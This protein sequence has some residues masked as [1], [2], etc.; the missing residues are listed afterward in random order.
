M[1]ICILRKKRKIK[2]HTLKTL[3][4]LMLCLCLPSIALAQDEAEEAA[5]E[6]IADGIREAVDTIDTRDKFTKIV[7]YNDFSWEYYSLGRPVLDSVDFDDHWNTEKIHAYKELLLSEIPNEVDILLVDSLH[8]FVPPIVGKVRSRYSFRRTRP[9]RGTDIPLAVGTPVRAAFD[10]KVRIAEFSRRTG[11]YGNLIVLRHAN[12][13][14]TYYGHLSKHNVHPDEVVKAGEII[15]YGGNTGRSTGPHLHFEARYMGQAFDPERI[16]DFE[17]GTLRDTVFT[18]KKHYFSIYSHYGQTEEESIAASQRMT[19]TIRSGDTLGG[20]AAKY[21]T[22]V[23]NICK[24]NNIS[25]STTLRIGRR[26]IV[27]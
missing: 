4:T 24:L 20:L 11:G 5:E 19:H 2:R 8:A 12:G 17:N 6:E 25:R 18:V 22:T 10:G 15:G 14:E 7:L 23:S 13:L 26:L 21:G 9:H 27:R 3:A 1:Y 16:I